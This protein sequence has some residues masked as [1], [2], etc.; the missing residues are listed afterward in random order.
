MPLQTKR[1]KQVNILFRKKGCYVC[2]ENEQISVELQEVTTTKLPDVMAI[3]T[4]NEELEEII[5]MENEWAEEELIEFEKVGKR[6]LNEVLRWN[7]KSVSSLR[8]V[9][10]GTSRTTKWRQ[11]KE[12]QKR[13]KHTKEMKKLDTFF[14]PVSQPS[15]SSPQSPSLLPQP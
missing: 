6:L 5:E 13:E 1:Q 15:F 4:Q 11:R 8:M 2:Q 12:E 7:E 10:T 3:T 14:Q 9:Y